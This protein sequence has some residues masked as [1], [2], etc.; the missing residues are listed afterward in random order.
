M[1][2]NVKDLINDLKLMGGFCFIDK[3]FKLVNSWFF[4][5]DV[6]MRD[7]DDDIL[8]VCWFLIKMSEFLKFIG[9]LDCNIVNLF[10]LRMLW[11]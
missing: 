5:Y 10:F 1:F 2:D 8:K 6:R 9:I 7:G 11:I 4:I 3:V